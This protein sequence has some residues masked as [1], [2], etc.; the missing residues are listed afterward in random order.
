MA[1]IPT[2]VKRRLQAQVIKPLFEEMAAR[3]GEKEARAVLDSAVRKAAI[4]EGKEFAAKSG[5][6]TSMADFIALYEH[7]KADGAL[8]IEVLKADDKTF[9]FDV[10]RCRY[11]EMYR[12]MGLGE[13]G[14]L[15]SRNR[16]G[17]FCTGYDPKI[18]LDRA[19]TIMAGADRC[20]FRYKYEG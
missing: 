11:A 1:E 4:A 9:D 7:W 14:A 17:T 15:M 19:K 18:T 6:K 12:E 13:I 5:G 20:T 8:E 2:I 16:D 3:F 10:K